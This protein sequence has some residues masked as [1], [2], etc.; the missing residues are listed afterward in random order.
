MLC[1]IAKLG[2]VSCWFQDILQLQPQ[3]HL[4]LLSENRSGLRVRI[5]SSLMTCRRLQM[6]HPPWMVHVDLLETQ[7]SLGSFPLFWFSPW[8]HPRVLEDAPWGAHCCPMLRK[9]DQDRNLT[10]PH[11]FCGFGGVKGR[12]PCKVSDFL[13][14][15]LLQSLRH[16]PLRGVFEVA[17]YTQIYANMIIL[18]FLLAISLKC[19]WSTPEIGWLSMKHPSA[20]EHETLSTMVWGVVS[21]KSQI[22]WGVWNPFPKR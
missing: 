4:F 16:S 20:N 7:W 19:R 13:H 21:L 22:C 12:K 17:Q 3:F 2:L 14:P 15:R 9:E 5:L 18:Y 10:A 11:V 1:T 8:D 6:R